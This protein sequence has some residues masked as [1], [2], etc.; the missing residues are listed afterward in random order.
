[1]RAIAVI[2]ANF[3]DEGK[4]RIV[5]H[6]A[7]TA[8]SPTI[9]IRYNG[10]A[11]AGHTVVT[12]EGLKHIFHHFGSG[13]LAGTSTWLSDYFIGNPFLWSMENK[14]L[15]D[16]GIKPEIIIHP[17]MPLSTP[18]DM[19]INREV[20]TWRG[21]KRH[22][23]CGYGIAETVERLC[24]TPYRTFIKDANTKEF[25]SIIKTIREDYSYK[26]LRN[27]G[28]S[29]PSDWFCESIMS[30]GLLEQYFEILSTM[31]RLPQKRT[32]Y[33]HK[34]K[35]IIFEG[36]QGLCLDE[37]HR[38]YPHVSRSKTGLSNITSICKKLKIKNIDVVYVTRAYL[39]RHG[40]GPL[41]T[42]DNSLQY[43]DETNTE[44]EWQGKLRFGYLD[45]DLL[46][47][48]I[49]HDIKTST[50][51]VNAN[52]ALTCYDQISENV[53]I[54]CKMQINEIPKDAL[55]RLIT[56]MT[57]VKNIIISKSCSRMNEKVK[58]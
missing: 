14:E 50:M 37:R 16:K 35:T 3:G 51:N 56:A 45:L 46:A 17:Y 26:R 21:N 24:R 29:K 49:K 28:I 55:P 20:E 31:I 11:Q 15:I 42:E 32:K 22:G 48:S 18:Y 41:P 9:V 27:L 12:P 8:E 23:S 1:M 40:A 39:T 4:G 2:G 58:N 52:I 19:L 54:K 47:E 7:F 38:F 5:D 33:L 10:G 36:S 13:T 34:Y 25:K 6:F 30:D 43:D 57:D 44:N 53:R